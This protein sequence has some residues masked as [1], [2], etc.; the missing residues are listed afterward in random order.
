MESPYCSSKLISEGLYTPQ[1]NEKQAIGAMFE[2]CDLHCF[3]AARLLVDCWLLAGGLLLDAGCCLQLAPPLRHL[4]L[5]FAAACRRR[6]RRRGGST[7][8]YT[9]FRGSLLA[10]RAAH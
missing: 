8:D 4:L 1:G 10:R 6:R 3:V 5:L 9:R 2:R 7:A